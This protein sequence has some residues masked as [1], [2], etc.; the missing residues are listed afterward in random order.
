MTPVLGRIKRAVRAAV[1]FSGGID[2]AAATVGRGRSTVGGW[3]AL[4]QSD[5]PPLDCVLALDEIAVAKGEL[6][7]I[8]AA[9]ALALGGLF[10]P[11]IDVGA[12]EGSPPH[13]AMMLAQHLGAVSGEI[14]ISL[15]DDGMIDEREAGLVLG[16][17]HDLERTAAQLRQQLT[18]IQGGN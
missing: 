16:R 11:N 8:T 4:H 7:P 1:G 14:A 15:A 5:M 17:L 18:R 6:P 9:L 12:E 2:G 13:L 10:V 3:N